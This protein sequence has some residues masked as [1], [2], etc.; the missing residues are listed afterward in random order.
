MTVLA[1]LARRPGGLAGVVLVVLVVGFALAGPALIADDPSHLDVRAR[2]APPSLRH[3]AGTDSLGR[4]MLARLAQGGRIALGV[5]L[6]AIAL[7]L[8]VG[9]PLG[10]AAARAGG[11][12]AAAI[13]VL[14]DIVA[15]FP[16]LLFA[17]AAVA[18]L[19]PGLP[20]LVLLVAITLAPQYGRVA[21]AQTLTLTSSG[22]LEA[23]RATGVPRL[24]LWRRHVLPNIAGPLLVL[25]GMDIPTVISLE[26]G[27]SFLGV[28]V[29][30]PSAS[31]G[32][33][34]YDGYVHLEQSVW[35]ILGAAAVLVLATLGFTLA[36]EA[37]RDAGD[38]T[39]PRGP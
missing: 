29:P 33:L 30:P 1:Q 7:A 26:A 8:A 17:L 23:A 28:G 32:A 14:F 5:A 20:R 31:W 19:G 34:L 15:A 13:L 16:S 24:R 11:P 21:R 9:T 18:L 27:L 4:D 39:L 38:P 2:F 12:V 37:L 10:I 22:F 6:A 25:A 3:W 35:P 36:G